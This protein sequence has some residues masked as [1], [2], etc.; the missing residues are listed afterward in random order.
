MD[1]RP[2]ASPLEVPVSW[3][4]LLDKITILE[5]KQERLSDPQ[6]LRN[7]TLELDLLRQ[8]TVGAAADGLMPLVTELG[9]VNR[10]LWDIEDAIREHEHRADFGPS[11]IELARAVYQNNDHRAAV[12]RRINLLLGSLLVEEKSYHGGPAHDGPA[13]DA[14]QQEA[15]SG[16]RPEGAILSVEDGLIRGWALD[17][18]DPSR[19]LLLALEVD[20]EPVGTFRTGLPSG[21]ATEDAPGGHG[22]AIEIRPGWSGEAPR[23]ISLRVAS[24]AGDGPPVATAEAV[25]RE[26]APSHLP[27]ALLRALPPRT[28]IIPENEE[29]LPEPLA[30]PVLDALSALA[31]AMGET[32]PD[33]PGRFRGLL[34]DMLLLPLARR[35]ATPDGWPALARLGQAML[36]DRP[37]QLAL[38]LLAVR[39]LLNARQY[40]EAAALAGQVVARWPRDHEARFLRGL[41]LLRGRR[42]DEAAELLRG[43]VLM[44]PG[45]GN[46]RAELSTALRRSALRPGLAPPAR[47]ALLEEAARE[48][49]TAAG[50]LPEAVP[51]LRLTAARCLAELG[52][53]EMALAQ[54]VGLP[55]TVETLEFRSK[56]L[57]ALNRVP[58]ALR[59][60]ERIL[61][62]D[63]TRGSAL[64]HLR[65]LRHLAEDEVGE[66]P[67][68]LASLSRVVE[69][70]EELF[71][72]LPWEDRDGPATRLPGGGA[73]AR[74]LQA[75]PADWLL[76]GEVPSPLPAD[77]Q[78]AARRAPSWCGLLRLPGPGGRTIDLWRTELLAGLARSGLLTDAA[79]L[80]DQLLQVR[81]D[82]ASW[83]PGAGDRWAP[84]PD[85]RPA[86][87]VLCVSRHG[88]VKFGGGEQFLESMAEHYAA[89]GYEPMIIG[90]QAQRAG[91]TGVEGGWPYAFV[92]PDADA[93]RRLVLEQ[94]PALV[95]V[96]SGLG[97]EVAEALD[98]LDVPFV[99]GV[100]YWR[101]CLGA[102]EDDGRF[103]AAGDRRPIARA[104]FRYVVQRAATI[105][106]NSEFTRDV[107]EEA[108]GF[109]A[110]VLLSLPRDEVPPD[111]LAMAEALTGGWRDFI[112]LLNT[113]E[114]KGFGLL[115]A[116]ARLLP[117]QPFI[118][119]ASQSGLEEA[120]RLAAGLPN[121]R[122][123][124]R[125]DRVDL[126]YRR[127][128]AVAVPSY[129]FVESFS[130]VCI[131]AQ[132]FGKPVLGS[133]KGNVPV[134]LAESGAVLPEEPGAW[135][136]AIRQLGR[137]AT[138]RSEAEAKATANAA[139]Y[140]Y[141]RQKPAL[142]G[143]V[144][145]IGDRLLVGVGSGIGNM[146][147]VGPMLRNIARKLG[148][149][150]DVV[151]TE[152][153]RD[154]L[155]LLQDEAS[156]NSVFP[157][158]QEVLR[159]RY[160]LVFLT[161]S[162]GNVRPP[163]QA[164]ATRNARD[165]RDFD[166][167]GPLHETQYNLESAREVLGIGYGP[168]DVTD[169]Y[170]GGLRYAPPGGARIGFHGG[171]KGGHWVSKRWPGHAELAARLAARGW[172]CASFGV[173]EEWVE[174]TLDL[175][176]GTIGEMARAMLS[177]RY[178]ISNDSGLMNIANAL[179]IPLTAVFA[180]TNPATRGPLRETSSYVALFKP[181][182]PCEAGPERR[183]IFDTGA[184]RCIGELPVDVV[185]VHV[186]DQLAQL[187][188]A[189]A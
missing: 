103:F 97:Q 59:L 185:E 145:T 70:G 90:A 28:G 105:Y 147:H 108:F 173:P 134:L 140:A 126:L 122:I 67:A 83:E 60:S 57:L 127:A 100:H 164:R 21:G 138:H 29:P 178:F 180:P 45:A 144:S 10:R 75:V 184:C 47:T 62:L 9:A 87:K 101:D 112:L 63:P 18:G 64:F 141:A 31:E 153:H 113:R 89:L 66:A 170:V 120:R 48:A 55:E 86:G 53:P 39:G 36:Q 4:E 110:P 79:A 162:F 166:P 129:H 7:V 93:I 61:A 49:E 40:E 116:V 84:R 27:P 76:L 50:M 176:G 174:G 188:L 128:L 146:L 102:T 106:A 152:D 157:L 151:V 43:A 82:V 24:P 46:Y 183:A 169:Y 130:R 167:A 143:I 104:T 44:R 186:L 42:E 175:T 3:G 114:E 6:A 37:Q 54:L 115:L 71:E 2:N 77:A 160:D 121:L 117:D 5:I 51:R 154:S 158:R 119:L 135:A 35:L 124:P 58:E 22:F 182:A 163:F 172:E 189:P 81:G 17:R 32:P 107:L 137:D 159:R 1:A 41:A 8:K 73:L 156:V 118:A 149:R 52:R 92:A 16:E 187:G 74:T 85:L 181:C 88:V 99:Y 33:N 20:G 23:R 69:R 68:R 11:F 38:A 30:P 13:G 26:A 80:G 125:V 34:E 95:H 155:F 12:K 19:P 109:R 179:G 133:D 168:E 15:L 148:R 65:A 165:W 94:R 150:V 96:L 25:L 132:R 161:H 171:S 123:L 56:Q 91:E 131:E 78:E 177:C 98:F 111:D 139:R 142:A 72:I 136:A 14:S